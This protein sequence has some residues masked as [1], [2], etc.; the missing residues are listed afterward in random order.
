[1]SLLHAYL[2]NNVMIKTALFYINKD[3][4][5]EKSYCFPVRK[6]NL[7]FLDFFC[8]AN[9]LLFLCFSVLCARI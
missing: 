8:M 3:K 1:M 6:N 2:I 7:L 9:C 4:L 5:L